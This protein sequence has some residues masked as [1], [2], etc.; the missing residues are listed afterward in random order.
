MLNPFLPQPAAWELNQHSSTELL[1]LP[2]AVG[3]Y[4]IM[5]CQMAVAAEGSAGKQG[6]GVLCACSHQ[7]PSALLSTCQALS[8]AIR[9]YF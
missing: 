1:S 7:C 4:W 6:A 8:H 2:G 5:K 3:T 9:G